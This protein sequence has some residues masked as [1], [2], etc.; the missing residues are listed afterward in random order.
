MKILGQNLQV[1]KKV[2]LLIV[3]PYNKSL[4]FVLFDIDRGSN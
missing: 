2:G 4:D 1:F 3:L